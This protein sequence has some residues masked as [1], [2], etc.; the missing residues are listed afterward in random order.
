MEC[1][2]H[3]ESSEIPSGY[4]TLDVTI[5]RECISY[6]NDNG[7]ISYRILTH[8]FTGK[9]VEFGAVFTPKGEI[10]LYSFNQDQSEADCKLIAAKKLSA[11]VVDPMY[12]LISEDTVYIIYNVPSAA[13][14]STTV[15]N[16]RPMLLGD[17]TAIAAGCP[18]VV[19]FNLVTKEQER[20]F[21]KMKSMMAYASHMIA[22]GD[23]PALLI[24]NIFDVEAPKEEDPSFVGLFASIFRSDREA[25]AFKQMPIGISVMR[26]TSQP[27]I[28]QVP[29]SGSE[30]LGI[31]S[32]ILEDGDTGEIVVDI[33]E[34]ADAEQT[35]DLTATKAS[36]PQDPA[37]DAV[38]E[39]EDAA[40]AESAGAANE[41]GHAASEGDHAPSEPDDAGPDARGRGACA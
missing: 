10:E 28:A 18:N 33:I 16:R 2:I 17:R 20:L 31:R 13:A 9:S 37:C 22:S 12:A 4:K 21:P 26:F 39:A 6:R 5:C 15:A 30:S 1:K 19:S 29:L 38:A 34:D 40:G 7:S 3:V 35:D 25:P 14:L 23:Q 11:S 24:A 41:D 8:K 27:E 32:V 36:D